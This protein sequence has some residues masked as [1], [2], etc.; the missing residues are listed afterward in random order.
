MN[1]SNNFLISLPWGI[2]HSAKMLACCEVF[3]VTNVKIWV[4]LAQRAR[5]FTKNLRL[6]LNHLHVDLRDRKS[7]TKASLHVLIKLVAYHNGFCQSFWDQ[8][9]SLR[10]L[11]FASSLVQFLI[12]C[13][14]L[15]IIFPNSDRK[16]QEIKIK[17]K[18]DWLIN[19]IENSCLKL[20]LYYRAHAQ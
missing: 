16:N 11:Q 12:T 7:H 10:D 8:I 4:W 14:I 18:F 20:L 2:L 1:V 6:Q 17:W 3:W 9:K 15:Y 5:A 19:C 13:T